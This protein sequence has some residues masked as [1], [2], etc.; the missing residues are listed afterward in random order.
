MIKIFIADDHVIIRE[1]LKKILQE[2]EDMNVVGEAGNAEELWEKIKSSDADII[3]LDLNFPGS[4]FFSLI[5]DLRIRLP[6]L[7]ILVVTIYPE[8]AYAIRAMKQGAHG[9]ITKSETL[10]TL[11]KAIRSIL[12]TGEYLS[13]EIGLILA[14]E[15]NEK[16]PGY[17]HNLLSTRELEILRLISK[18]KKVKEI[19]DELSLSVSTV[20]TYRLRIFKKMKMATDAEIVKYALENKLVY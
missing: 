1:G 16:E 3:L 4:G 8:K 2:I 12:Q 9:F 17:P 18:G 20:N 7:F 14:D 5:S 19:S 13:P 6:Q 15:L 11:E 10:E